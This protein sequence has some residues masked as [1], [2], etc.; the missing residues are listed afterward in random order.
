M[1]ADGSVPSISIYDSVGS[2]R[3]SIGRRGRGPAEF[4]A[5]NG[6]GLV[7]DTLWVWDAQNAR[8]SFFAPT[9]RLVGEHVLVLLE[10][11][12]RSRIVT[13]IGVVEGR[14]LHV[15]YDPPFEEK[16]GGMFR[17][18]ILL[19]DS[20]GTTVLDTVSRSVV[21]ER[22]IN[23]PNMPVFNLPFPPISTGPLEVSNGSR[24]FHI[25]RPAARRGEEAEFVV[26]LEILGRAH[27]EVRFKYA[28]IRT[29]RD[30]LRDFFNRRYSDPR[31]Q[32]AARRA[33]DMPEFLPPIS[34]AFADDAGRLWLRR[35]E[36]QR[37]NPQWLVLD[38]AL[39][40]LATFRFP[41][42]VTEQRLSGGLFWV[43]ERNDVDDPAVVGYRFSAFSGR[44]N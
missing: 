20:L 35:E 27:G 3:L 42:A 25:E 1:I 2:R 22:L 44:R 43:I 17:R 6:V 19:T 8:L 38:A 30:S 15:L 10:N 7:G 26:R 9:G 13:I 41:G 37:A 36:Y 16:S 33:L 12:Q 11:T 39:R 21:A 5:I 4:T 40:P 28:P 31:A 14:K 18:L 32:F 34:A 24:R 29:P 23:T